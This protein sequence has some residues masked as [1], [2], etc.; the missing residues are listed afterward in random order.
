MS[1]DQQGC[2]DSLNRGPLLCSSN[3]RRTKRRSTLKV[4]SVVMHGPVPGYVPDSGGED[5]L[6]IM[7]EVDS[8]ARLLMS[9][10][11]APPFSLGIFGGSGSGK[12]FFA[13]VL[14]QRIQARSL[15]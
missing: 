14:Q 9:R 10:T 3:R 7:P 4:V 15:I 12:S 8:L 5:L 6:G 13:K 2:D 1:Y 11:L